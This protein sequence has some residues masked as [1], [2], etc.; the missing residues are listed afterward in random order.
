MRLP[1]SKLLLGVLAF[2]PMVFWFTLAYFFFKYPAVMLIPG[3][4][5]LIAKERLDGR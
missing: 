2:T 4:I 1:K 3:L 5:A